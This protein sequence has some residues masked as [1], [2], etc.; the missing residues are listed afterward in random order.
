MGGSTDKKREEPRRSASES[1]LDIAATLPE[2]QD[3]GIGCIGAG[4]IMRDVHLAAY[5]EAGFPVVAIASR[6]AA[7]ARAAAR[8]WGI[9]RVYES[10]ESLI[11]DP[12]VSVLDIAYPPHEQ[13][14]IIRAAAQAKNVRGIL[15]QKPLAPTLAEAR[16]LVSLCAQA[17]I[18]LAVNQNMRYD[19]SIRALKSLLRDGTLG[20]P[21]VAQLVMN[22]D[23]HWQD[24]IRRYQRVVLLNLSVHHLDVYRYLFGDPSRIVA[25]V[26]PD[27]KLDFP[28]TDGSA[29]YV[30]EYDD[31]LRAIGLDN[32]FTTIDPRLEW[33]V[34]G[35][36]GVAKGV[37]GWPKSYETPSTIDF[38]LRA[39]PDRWARPR[40]SERWFPQAFIGTMAQLLTA[41]E[42][43]TEPEISGRDN[44]R[45]MALVEA[46]YTSARE[47]RAVSLDEVLA[48]N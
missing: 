26:R 10:V 34:E 46:A 33:R 15:A 44:L 29:F 2:R 45:T 25:S 13:I 3:W 48:A 40:W 9:P 42:T 19:Q 24:Y 14:R 41:L 22:T 7:N 47:G 35:T 28:H 11:A 17:E 27:P 18:A 4:W 1:S 12:E 21:V 37:I 43:D 5:A 23:A 6:T 30:L 32:C 20:Q 8:Q 16:D 38:A 31:G 39:D 36:G